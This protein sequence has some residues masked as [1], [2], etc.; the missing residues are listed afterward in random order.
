MTAPESPLSGQPA[1]LQGDASSCMLQP[2]ASRLGSSFG[3]SWQRNGLQRTA[4]F[5]SI[6]TLHHASHAIGRQNL[7]T[8][9]FSLTS[10]GR[11]GSS[12]APTTS[13]S[14]NQSLTV[15]TWSTHSRFS[16]FSQVFQTD[17]RSSQPASPLAS[18]P[19]DDTVTTRTYDQET[20][21]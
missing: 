15:Q 10:S 6:A 7:H 3:L 9:T 18:Q 8:S 13:L 2:L 1:G 19:D 20:A 5:L 16:K 17:P 21:V 4:I 11:C 14:L 12:V